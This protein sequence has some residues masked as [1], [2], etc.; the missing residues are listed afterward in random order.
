[1]VLFLFIQMRR[2]ISD[3]LHLQYF[4]MDYTGTRVRDHRCMQERIHPTCNLHLHLQLLFVP[5]SLDPHR[6]KESDYNSSHMRYTRGH[7]H[8]RRHRQTL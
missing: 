7:R 3:I 4:F 1:M 6:E 2:I 5:L 8:A